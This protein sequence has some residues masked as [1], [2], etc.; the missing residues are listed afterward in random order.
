MDGITHSLQL[1]AAAIAGALMA[2][3]PVWFWAWRQKNSI[4]IQ[5]AKDAYEMSKLRS[6]DYGKEMTGLVDRMSA[7]IL[8]LEN[9]HMEC[10]DRGNKQASEIYQLTDKCTYLE[11]QVKI[12]R[13]MATVETIKKLDIATATAA[14][15]IRTTAAT[16]AT[17]ATELIRATA[18][19]ASSKATT[20]SLGD[21]A[22]DNAAK[23]ERLKLHDERNIAQIAQTKEDLA[24]L[25]KVVSLGSISPK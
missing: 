7:R 3:L 15:L 21:I 17:T 20:D 23:I 19:A 9:E 24:K 14:E 25:N 18:L 1:L 6:S 16:A 22:A 8:A 2:L 12:L 4:Q 11:T 5:E 10:Q 13:E